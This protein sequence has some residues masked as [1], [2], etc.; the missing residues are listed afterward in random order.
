MANRV[1]NKAEADRL[2]RKW[3]DL[4]IAKMETVMGEQ[5]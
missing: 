5:E 3:A 2:F 1:T 4:L